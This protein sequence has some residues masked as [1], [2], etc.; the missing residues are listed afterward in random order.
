[1]LHKEGCCIMTDQNAKDQ[2]RRQFA[3]HAERYV[4]SISHAAGSDLAFMTSAVQ[5]D[6]NMRLLDI[7]TGGGHVANAFAPLVGW[8]TATDLTP[9]MLQKAEEFI[10]KNGHSNVEFVPAD[11]EQLP[12]ADDTFEL[13]TCRIAAHHFSDVP[14]FAAEAYRV[15]KPGGRLLLIDN[16]A[17]E[18]DELDSF[19]NEIEKIRDPSH[20][21]AWKKSEW[22]GMLEEAG[23]VIEAMVRFPKVHVFQDWCDRVELPDTERRQLEDK[24]LNARAPLRRYLNVVQEENGRLYSF[25]GE[26]VFLHAAKL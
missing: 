11:A 12:F 26:S 4:T 23:F 15:T 2:V 14:A 7:A 18:R 13:V 9:E 22:L 10:R 6:A 21:R 17:L 3:K 1:M 5:T 24:L 20:V 8:V 16:V 19:Y 25:T